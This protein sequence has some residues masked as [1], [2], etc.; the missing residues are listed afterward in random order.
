VPWDHVPGSLILCEAGGIARTLDGAP[1][2]AASYRA[3]GLL[4][5]ADEGTWR[6]VH[7]TLF[8]DAPWLTG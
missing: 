1:Y 4:L 5:A 6:T 7:D 8:G 2:A 3:A